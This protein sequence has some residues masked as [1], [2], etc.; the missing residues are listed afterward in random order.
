MPVAPSNK[1]ALVD[2]EVKAIYKLICKAGICPDDQLPQLKAS[3]GALSSAASGLCTLAPH[4]PEGW[5][6]ALGHCI[7]PAL[8]TTYKVSHYE[9]VL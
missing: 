9:D 4:A 8:V 7:H 2:K 5:V 6:Q 1:T 3:R